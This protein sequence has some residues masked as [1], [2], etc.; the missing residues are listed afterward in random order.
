MNIKSN[1][2]SL[3]EPLWCLFWY[4]VYALARLFLFG[5]SIWCAITVREKASQK[6]QL[7]TFAGLNPG[8]NQSQPKS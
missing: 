7:E 8:M 3:T 6:N 4:A 5:A 1:P 2:I